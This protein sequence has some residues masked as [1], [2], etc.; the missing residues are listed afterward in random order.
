[1]SAK[2]QP[3]AHPASEL[4]AEIARQILLIETLEERRMDSLDF[5]EVAVWQVQEALETAFDAGRK[6]RN[7]RPPKQKKA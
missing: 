1:M 7:K 2:P 6:S 5:H 3:P 4:I